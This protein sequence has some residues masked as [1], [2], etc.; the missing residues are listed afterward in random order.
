MSP[1]RRSLPLAVAA[2]AALAAAALVPA[3]ARAAKDKV[4]IGATLPLTGGEARVGGFFKEGYELAFEEVNKKGGLDVGGKKLPGPAHPPRRHLDAGD[5]GE[6]RGPAREQRQGRLPARHLREPPHRGAVH[7]RR[8]EQDPVRERR[9][10][11]D[12]DLQARVQVPL[13]PHLA[14]RAARHDAHAVDRRAA[15]GGQAAEAREDRARSGRTPPTARTS[16]RASPTSRR[17][18]AARTRSRSTSRSS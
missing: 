4:V 5:R 1:S 11:G 14:R 17:R 3:P 2:V 16:A 6:P 12:Q 9:R 10:R 8:G 15:E 7:R 18:A 13:R